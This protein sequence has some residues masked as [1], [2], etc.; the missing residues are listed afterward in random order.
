M[1]EL[2]IDLLLIGERNYERDLN[3]SKVIMKKLDGMKYSMVLP[4]TYIIYIIILFWKSMIIY[5]QVYDRWGYRVLYQ[6]LILIIFN[7]SVF[8]AN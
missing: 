5:F 7:L 2:E 8:I 3:N 4:K 1:R 6:S